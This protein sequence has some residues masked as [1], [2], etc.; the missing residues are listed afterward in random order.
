M[1][2]LVP[3]PTEP[4]DVTGS[5][6]ALSPHRQIFVSHFL[7]TWSIK[8]AAQLSKTPL[9]TA[10]YWM[11]LQEVKDA[12]SEKQIDVAQRCDI[13]YEECLNILAKIARFEHSD[14]AS[15]FRMNLENGEIGLTLEAFDRMDTSVIQEMSCKVN[16]Q[17]IPYVVIKPYN[18][19]EALK[20]LLTRLQGNMGGEQHLHLHLNSEETK[21]MSASE[22][23]A[24]YQQMVQNAMTK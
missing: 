11:T 18:K 21:K 14:Y 2:E 16:A 9:R 19:L 4:R 22:L 17:G 3:V 20:E 23:S 15:D 10:T 6:S 24:N 12:I 5:Y 7:A 13:T 8:R 1:E